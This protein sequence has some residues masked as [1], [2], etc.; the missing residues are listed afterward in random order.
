M[1][2]T[3]R[4]CDIALGELRA[5]ER[6]KSELKGNK[7]LEETLAKLYAEYSVIYDELSSE[8]RNMRKIRRG[9]IND[10]KR[11]FSYY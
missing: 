4:Q 5:V 7:E 11:E 3:R 9:I 2:V 10:T 1:P 8:Y 6:L